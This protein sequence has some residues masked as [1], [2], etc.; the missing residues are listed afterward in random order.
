MIK[1]HMEKK[2]SINP[3]EYENKLFPSLPFLN[4]PQFFQMEQ[5]TSGCSVC[6]TVSD[7]YFFNCDGFF[8][9]L[10]ELLEDFL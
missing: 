3:L 1:K 9:L 7:H 6:N 10:Q 5:V 2:I 4:I 8:R